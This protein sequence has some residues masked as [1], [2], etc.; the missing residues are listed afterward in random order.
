MPETQRRGRSQD[1]RTEKHTGTALPCSPLRQLWPCQLT[2]PGSKRRGEKP[3][4]WTVGKEGAG[5]R[6]DEW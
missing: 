5:E 2:L 6:L 1:E 4:H 3:W